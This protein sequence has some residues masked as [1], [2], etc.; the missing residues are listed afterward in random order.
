M[1][2]TTGMIAIIV[3]VTT[4]TIIGIENITT[5]TTGIGTIEIAMI[6]TTGVR[7]R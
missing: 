1:G 5:T 4:G 6:V 3:I 7:R 2:A